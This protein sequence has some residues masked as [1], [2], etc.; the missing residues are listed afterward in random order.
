MGG[1]FKRIPIWRVVALPLLSL[2]LIGV[3]VGGSGCAAGR[4]GNTLGASFPQ[5]IDAS[6][7]LTFSQTYPCNFWNRGLAF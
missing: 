1:L 7:R 4:G 2:G 3:A 6:R 5:C